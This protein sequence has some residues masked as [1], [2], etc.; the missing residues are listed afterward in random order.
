MSDEYW[1]RWSRRRK[2]PFFRDIFGDMDEVFKE[3]EEMIERDFAEFSKRAP[4]DLMRE[5]ELPD[6]S[7]V[8]EWGPFVYG[9]S[10]KIG[11]DGKPEI[12]EFGNVK[13]GI[14]LGRPRI[15]IKQEMEPLTDIIETDGQ[16]KVIVEVP[17]VEKEHIKLHGTVDALTI[18]VDAPQRKYH[19]QVKLPAKV[20]PK[21]AKA[22]CKNGV[23]EVTISKTKKEKPEG[24]PISL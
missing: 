8:Q 19:K 3:I 10:M 15:D 9:Y 21:Q 16:I 5:R 4:K 6:G 20:N 24:E 12:R 2:W 17:G 18:S 23:L 22:S 13:P 14:E 7:R 1:D 11:P